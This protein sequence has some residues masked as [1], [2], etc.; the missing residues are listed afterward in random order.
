MRA[1]QGSDGCAQSGLQRCVDRMRLLK[2]SSERTTSQ[3]PGK[4]TV[5]GIRRRPRVLGYL[6]QPASG[7]H[8]M[9][10]RHTG[11]VRPGHI[12]FEPPQRVRG[13]AGFAAM[14]A[15]FALGGRV[16]ADGCFARRPNYRAGRVA[17]NR[18]ADVKPEMG[19]RARRV[20]RVCP[21]GPGAD[22]LSRRS[23][24][25]AVGVYAA[26]ARTVPDGLPR[27]ERRAERAGRGSSAL[28]LP[29]DCGAR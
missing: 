29:S 18:Q 9:Q 3:R 23:G 22:R 5:R 12:E 4:P 10:G 24:Q 26:V 8:R 17:R 19:R 15:R 25:A 28:A 11:F 6:G 2:D 14:D 27:T 16:V 21:E 7:L 13:V 1:G 20:E